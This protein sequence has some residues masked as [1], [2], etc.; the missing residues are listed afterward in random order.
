MPIA[1]RST[2]SRGSELHGW[3][4][5]D[6]AS[7]DAHGWLLLNEQPAHALMP[8]AAGLAAAWGDPQLSV[9]GMGTVQADAGLPA[10]HT[11][12]PS[13]HGTVPWHTEG[14]YLRHPPQ[15]LLLWCQTAG[16]AGGDTLLLDGAA[17]ARCLPQA[18]A[19]RLRSVPLAVCTGDYRAVHRLLAPAGSQAEVLRFCDPAIAPDCR[20]ET[21]EGEHALDVTDAVRAALA[22]APAHRHAWRA[23]DLLVI[24]NRRML[25]ARAAFTGRR[26]LQRVLVGRSLQRWGHAA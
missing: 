1:A 12:A 3:S 6:L 19:Q 25:H 4:T 23:G 2:P 9:S 20:I 16:D 22:D 5:D 8:R 13:T 15:A 10:R 11:A 7:L 14:L 24:D 17:A 21:A 18:L 26:L